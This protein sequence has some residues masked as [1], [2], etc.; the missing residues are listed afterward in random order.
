VRDERKFENS[1]SD[2]NRSHDNGSSHNNSRN[3][4][5]RPIPTANEDNRERPARYHRDQ[6]DGS[7]PVGFGEDI[8][9]FMLIV[10][11]AGAK[12]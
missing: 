5:A 3:N 11:N 9:A 8:P 7:T 2:S 4:N 12:G 10:A 1:R 6:D